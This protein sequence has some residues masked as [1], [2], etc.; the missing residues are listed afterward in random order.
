MSLAFA[1]LVFKGANEAAC[2]FI[3]RLKVTKGKL[4]QGM[5]SLLCLMENNTHSYYLE[6]E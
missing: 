6:A 5:K 4:R 1:Y 2:C 3:I